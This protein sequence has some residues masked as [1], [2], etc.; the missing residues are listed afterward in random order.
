M[1]EPAPKTTLH[2]IRDKA[3]GLYWR[4]Q[5]RRYGQVTRTAWTD[6]PAMAWHCHEPEHVDRYFRGRF[7]AAQVPDYEVVTF[8]M[9]E[10]G[11]Q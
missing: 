4:G 8:E 11:V 3:T 5:K 10:Q 9:V 1:T 7:A 2:L 6:S